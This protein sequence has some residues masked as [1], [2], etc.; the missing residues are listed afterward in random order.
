MIDPQGFAHGMKETTGEQLFT[1][2]REDRNGEFA[3][4]VCES[5]ASFATFCSS[6][7]ALSSG[8][9]RRSNLVAS[10]AAA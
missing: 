9:G 7:R 4:S 8:G 2:G 5:F 3:E 10:L 6:L 1:E